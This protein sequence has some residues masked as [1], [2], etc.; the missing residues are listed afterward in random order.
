MNLSDFVYTVQKLETGNKTGNIVVNI[1]YNNFVPDSLYNMSLKVL[2]T[3]N[4]TG[5]QSNTFA[6]YS[7]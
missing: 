3:V 6:G 5:Q 1:T 7:G 2:E 4:E